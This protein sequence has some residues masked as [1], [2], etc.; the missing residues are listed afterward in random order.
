VPS[1]RLTGYVRGVLERRRFM[2]SAFRR[3]LFP[4]AACA[5]AVC[6]AGPA[7]AA[8]E[9]AEAGD[10]GHE[11]KVFTLLRDLINEGAD[12]YNGG[13]YAGCYHFWEGALKALRPTLEHHEAWQKAVDSSLAEARGTPTMWQRA[14]VL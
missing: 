9:P 10:K 1:A 6:L 2:R 12:L 14:W 3:W 8:D 4:L 13:D 11:E 5:V 7:R